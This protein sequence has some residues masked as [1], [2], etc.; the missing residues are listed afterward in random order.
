MYILQMSL[1]S[2]TWLDTLIWA[3]NQSKSLKALKQIWMNHK[4][5]FKKEVT[6]IKNKYIS[7][8]VFYRI[9]VVIITGG[10]RE[11]ILICCLTRAVFFA[12]QKLFFAECFLCLFFGAFVCCLTPAMFSADLKFLFFLIRYVFLFVSVWR[13]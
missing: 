4:Y 3:R 5:L 6:L 10:M 11:N 1:Y 2:V 13:L 7:V 12:D 8:F 9:F